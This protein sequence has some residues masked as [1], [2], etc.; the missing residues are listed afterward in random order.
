MLGVLR[1][2]LCLGRTA[3]ERVVDNDPTSDFRG[4]RRVLVRVELFCERLT[5]YLVLLLV[6]VRHYERSEQCGVQYNL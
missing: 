4:R 5:V 1:R 3:G 6:F 2:L